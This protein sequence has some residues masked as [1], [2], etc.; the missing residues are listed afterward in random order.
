MPRIDNLFDQLQGAS[1]FSK[2]DFRSSYLQLRIKE[3]DIYK[4]VFRMRY[5]D[6]EFTVMPF[7]LAK[8][9]TTFMDIMNRVFMSFLDMFVVVFIDYIIVYSKDV[10]DH[11][12]HLKISNGEIEGTPIVRQT[13]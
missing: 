12:S 11:K 8:A 3:C 2:I 9:P 10:E 4:T 7:G 6:F 5:G 13:Q 1:I